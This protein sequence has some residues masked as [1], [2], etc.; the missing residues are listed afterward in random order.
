MTQDY[1]AFVRF[2]DGTEQEWTGLRR[3]QAT[4]R[5]HWVSR[6]SMSFGKQV[7]SYSWEK[8]A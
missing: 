5:F 1:R 8:V 3:K 6:N 7:A 2:T 4:W